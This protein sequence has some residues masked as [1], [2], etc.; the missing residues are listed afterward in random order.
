MRVWKPAPQHLYS[1]AQLSTRAP[2]SGSSTTAPPR[3]GP[4]H[5][6][7]ELGAKLGIAP[8]AR[9]IARAE[10]CVRRRLKQQPGRNR[11]RHHPVN[12]VRGGRSSIANAPAVVGPPAAW[13]AADVS[14]NRIKRAAGVRGIMAYARFTEHSTLLPSGSAAAAS[15]PLH[16]VAKGTGPC[17]EAQKLACASRSAT[18]LAACAASWL[19]RRSPASPPAQ[20]GMQRRASAP[21]ADAAAHCRKNWAPSGVAAAI[22]VCAGRTHLT[23][24]ALSRPPIRAA[25]NNARLRPRPEYGMR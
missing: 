16:A 25:T 13:S 7:A 11:R 6:G 12:V 14:A 15:R 10:H 3:K 21:G 1:G 8:A 24:H 9:V 2:L 19:P 20:A 18:L 4:L 22:D 23:L 5:L 17:T